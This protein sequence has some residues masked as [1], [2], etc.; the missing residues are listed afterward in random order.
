MIASLSNIHHPRP[1]SSDNDNDP[2]PTPSKKPKKAQAKDDAPD[3]YVGYGRIIGRHLGPFV[4]VAAVIEYGCKA[5]SAMSGDEEETDERLAE[6]WTIL[7]KKFPGFHE[8]LLSISNK[9]VERRAIEKQLTIGMEAVR[10]EDTLT[11]KTRIPAWLHAD[12]TTPLDPALPNLT[13]KA[14]RGLTHPTFAKLLTPMEW[15]ANETTYLEI[16]QG[17][18]HVTGAQL[19]AFVFPLGQEFPIGEDLDHPAW[20]AVL[21]NALKGEVLLRSGKA[22]YMG[23]NSALEGEGFHKGRPGNASVIGLITFSRRTIAGV[24]TQVYFGLSSKQE[25]YKTDGDHF[26]YEEFFWTIYDLFDNEEWG[27]EII[28]LWNQ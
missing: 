23:P 12:P 15:P 26:N 11:L 6:A 16:A 10:S 13:S 8:Y 14:H 22:M 27:E 4:N 18:K 7:W 19:P 5:D 25:W 28:C 2:E 9:P 17:E 1:E 24:A 20:E 3:D 21:D